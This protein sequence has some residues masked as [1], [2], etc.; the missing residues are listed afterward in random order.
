MA[1]FESTRRFLDHLFPPTSPYNPERDIP[2]LTGKVVIVTGGNG[3]VGRE[4]VKHLLSKNAKVYMAS[5]SQDLA[6][7]AIR[8]LKE[9]TGKEAI[10][11]E[12]DLSGL[13]KVTRAANEF[14]SKESELHILFNSAATLGTPLQQLSDEGVELQ[15]GTN[16][17]GPAHFTL[18]L[19]PELV[20]GAK[21]SPDGKA[22]V[23]N[24]S[25][26]GVYLNHSKLINW[27]SLE[28]DG[29][30]ER[31]K[32]G[33]LPLYNQSKYAVLAFSNEL[34]RRYADQGITSNALNPGGIRTRLFRRMGSFNEWFIYTF[35]TY[36]VEKGPLTSLYVGTSPETKDANGGWF[37]PFA[38]RAPHDRFT[39][40]A[41]IE[42]RLWDWIEEKR[43]GHY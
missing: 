22:R 10:F 31:K 33:S 41:E 15:F 28:T 35:L 6:E 2:D 39:K 27:E 30:A 18:L 5:R 24:V 16:V 43:K 34:A 38:R 11:L 29:T 9:E 3:G 37:V 14:K 21:A 32:L 7:Q 23:V 17:L 42:A 12:L 4:T 8:E 25:S 13:D 36:P 26:S 19:I 40:N 20:A 1:A